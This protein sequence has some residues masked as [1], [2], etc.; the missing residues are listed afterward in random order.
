MPLQWLL[1]ICYWFCQVHKIGI[2][3]ALVWYNMTY[4]IPVNVS[5]YTKFYYLTAIPYQC[6]QYPLRITLHLENDFSGHR[7]KKKNL[8]LQSHEAVREACLYTD[9]IQGM[10]RD[11]MKC[12]GLRGKKKNTVKPNPY[13][14]T[15]SMIWNKS[16]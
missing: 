10:G 16:W 4:V 3:A 7:S 13:I 15:Q 14:Y 6:S 9:T 2:A 5:C 1:D 11:S 8:W 12:Q